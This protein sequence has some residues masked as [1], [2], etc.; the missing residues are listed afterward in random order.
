M[1]AT[2]KFAITQT[3]FNSTQKA[4]DSYAAKRPQVTHCTEKQKQVCKQLSVCL[5]NAYNHGQKECLGSWFVCGLVTYI[6]YVTISEP[7]LQI[8]HFKIYQV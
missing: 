1:I 4:T 5:F 2:D 8:H 6:I 3:S 7:V